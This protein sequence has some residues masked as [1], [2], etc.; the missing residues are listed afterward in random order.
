[1]GNFYT[2]QPTEMAQEFVKR[3]RVTNVNVNKQLTIHMSYEHK[4]VKWSSVII[5]SKGARNVDFEPF[6]VIFTQHNFEFSAKK[7]NCHF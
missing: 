6:W 3:A 1:M 5:R 4:K 7:L 2:T